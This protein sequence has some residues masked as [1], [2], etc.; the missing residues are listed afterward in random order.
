MHV[1]SDSFGGSSP[2]R[3]ASD[4][5]RTL[6]T[7][8]AAKVILDQLEGSGRG[9]LASYNTESYEE[10]HQFLV[11][12]PMKDGDAWLTALM[13]QNS[14]LAV[15]VMEVRDAYCESDFEW[16][17]LKWMATREMKGANTKLMQNHA[18]NAFVRMMAPDPEGEGQ[19]RGRN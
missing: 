18:E 10:L 15:R 13:Q 4:M 5:L 1:P 6:F 19:A 17:T 14:M 3:K 16:D 9:S 11:D 12:V 2:E 7:F 8:V